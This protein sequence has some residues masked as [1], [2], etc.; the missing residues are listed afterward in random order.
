MRTYE[1]LLADDDV[2]GHVRVAEQARNWW[3]PGRLISSV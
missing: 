2:I 3:H 1:V